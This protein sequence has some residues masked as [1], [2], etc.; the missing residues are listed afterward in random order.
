MA[1]G[2]ALDRL[3]AKECILHAT[4]TPKGG[5]QDA[6]GAY[7]GRKAL[8]VK[9]S[10]AHADG[11]APDRRDGVVESR[12][13]IHQSNQGTARQRKNSFSIE[14]AAM[15]GI[16]SGFRAARGV[17]N[18]GHYDAKILDLFSSESSAYLR[19]STESNAEAS[20]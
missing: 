5:H 18:L 13:P 10:S 3:D 17:E 19:F 15:D 9:E 2:L 20:D 11:R 12:R 14:S 7:M 8:R 1:F 16:N 4:G 6:R